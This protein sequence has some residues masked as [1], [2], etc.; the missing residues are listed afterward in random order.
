MFQ[1][2]CC[3]S[4]QSSGCT[5]I[6]FERSSSQRGFALQR[7]LPKT[8]KQNRQQSWNGLPPKS[9]LQ[10]HRNRNSFH[11]NF[12]F[13]KFVFRLQVFVRLFK[14]DANFRR[15]SSTT[16]FVRK[17]VRFSRFDDCCKHHFDLHGKNPSNA[18]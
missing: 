6:G 15:K 10:K 13:R 8:K 7:I 2:Y 1:T 9:R 14:I 3:F 18:F 16:F 12:G 4:G 17:L 5:K 11:R